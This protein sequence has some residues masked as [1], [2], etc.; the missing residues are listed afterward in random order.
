ML[1]AHSGVAA[2]YPSVHLAEA[3]AI[4]LPASASADPKVLAPFILSQQSAWIAMLTRVRD[5]I[6][7]GFGLKTARQL[8]ALALDGKDERV[9]I[10]RIYSVSETA[11]VIREASIGCHAIVLKP[12][13]AKSDAC[14]SGPRA[15]ARAPRGA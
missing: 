12:D 15:A 14:T 4:A 8:A 5:L 9:G 2:I 1:P 11:M 6:V 10:F 13:M 3:F 7:A